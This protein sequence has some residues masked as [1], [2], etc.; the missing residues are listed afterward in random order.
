M[1]WSSLA[2]AWGPAIPILVVMLKAHHDVI[3]KVFP[4]A[5]KEIRREIKEGAKRADRRHREHVALQ[6]KL[7]VLIEKKSGQRVPKTKRKKA[8][9]KK[10]PGRG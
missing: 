7:C 3:Y 5:I 6:E 10:V 9:K 2:L 1:D 4:N 8:A